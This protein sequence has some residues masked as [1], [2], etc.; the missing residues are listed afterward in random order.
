[1]YRADAD[2]VRHISQE[3]HK[4]SPRRIPELREVKMQQHAQRW[5][6][7]PTLS[8]IV[9]RLFFSVLLRRERPAL[10]RRPPR[11]PVFDSCTSVFVGRLASA[12]GSTM[13][14]HSCDS[15]TDRTW[16]TIV[17]HR[18]H[19]PG[20]MGKVYFEPKRSKGP[21]DTD[22]METGEIPLSGRRPMP[23]STPPIRS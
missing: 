22:R 7:G 8:A 19:P 12:D 17:P 18:S 20:E 9:G 11:D 21:D 1:M 2:L 16:I 5:L 3:R 6:K 13:T 4:I 14:S 23:T 15:G 10:V